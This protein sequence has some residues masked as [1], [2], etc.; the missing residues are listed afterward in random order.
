ME[1]LDRIGLGLGFDRG[2]RAIDDLSAT[3][4]LPSSMRLF[5][6]FDRI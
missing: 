1:Q 5:M 4:F 6:N 3:A 2:E